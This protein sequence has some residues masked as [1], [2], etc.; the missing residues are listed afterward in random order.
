MRQYSFL[1]QCLRMVNESLQTFNGISVGTQRQNPG[2]PVLEDPMTLQEQKHSAGLM[3]VNHT[4]EVCAQALYQGQALTARNPEIAQAMRQSALEE[5]DHLNWCEGR[6]HELN[7]RTSFLN[8][9]WW[10]GSFSIGIAAGLAGDKWS[11]GFL[12]ETEKQVCQHLQSHLDALPQNDHKSKAI[13]AQMQWDEN[14]HAVHALEYGGV[15]LPHPIQWAMRLSSKVM[16][17]LTYYV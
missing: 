4:G 13:V 12:A 14:Q 1:D 10:M 17:S 7:S 16:T 6:L 3:R 5:Q 15:A 11:L 8:P 9:L 2:E